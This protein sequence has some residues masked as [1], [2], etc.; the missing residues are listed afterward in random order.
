MIMNVL[1]LLDQLG[2]VLSRD[3]NKEDYLAIEV[4][5]PCYPDLSTFS[6]WTRVEAVPN[7]ILVAAVGFINFEV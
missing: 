3:K 5:Y 1:V 7:I 4:F 6:F 2:S